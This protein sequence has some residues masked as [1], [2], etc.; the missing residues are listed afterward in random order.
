VS[1]LGGG[2]QISRPKKCSFWDVKDDLWLEEI[3][4]QAAPG[5]ALKIRASRSDRRKR[6]R[7]S[8]LVG[9]RS[10]FLIRL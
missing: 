7:P 8:I 10:F 3:I 1:S 5:L 6:V 2:I 4:S 9:R